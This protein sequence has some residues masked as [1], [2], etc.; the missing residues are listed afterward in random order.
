MA[1]PATI[2]LDAQSLIAFMIGKQ[3]VV[4]LHTV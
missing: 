2:L 1:L 3:K 4:S